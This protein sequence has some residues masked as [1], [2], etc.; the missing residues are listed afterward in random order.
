MQ[1]LSYGYK[2]PETNDK[3][4]VVFP[5]MEDNIDQLNDHDHDGANSAKLTT[6]SLTVVTQTILAAGWVS[7]GGGNFSQQVTL[8]PGYDFDQITLS[9]RSPVNGAYLYPSVVK[10]SSTVVEVFCNDASNMTM[11]YGV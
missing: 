11:V 9:F 6:K 7:L 10:V 4:P 8:L 1:T 3:G 5:A 2:K